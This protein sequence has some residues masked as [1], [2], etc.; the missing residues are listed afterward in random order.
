[1]KGKKTKKCPHCGASMTVWRHN[2]N[3]GLVDSLRKMA[4]EIRKTGV[5]SVNVRT[6][7]NLTKVRYNNFQKLRYFGLVHHVK[8]NGMSVKGNWL[9]TKRGWAFLRGDIAV[10]RYILTF[11]NRIEAR[12]DARKYIFEIEDSHNPNY[13]KDKY[14]IEPPFEAAGNHDLTIVDQNF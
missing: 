9:I 1:M 8:H 2:I 11:R 12:S 13:F 7:L 14:N 5:N 4:N 10:S 6:E 3:I